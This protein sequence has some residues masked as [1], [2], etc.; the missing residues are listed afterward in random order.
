MTV[1]LLEYSYKVWCLFFWVLCQHFQSSYLGPIIF[2]CE[3]MLCQILKSYI[4]CTSLCISTPRP[5]PLPRQK[6]LVSTLSEKKR[7]LPCYIPTTL[8][9]T[10]Y[11]STILSWSLMKFAWLALST[12]PCPSAAGC[13]CTC[14]QPE[15]VASIQPFTKD[16][17]LYRVYTEKSACYKV[18]PLVM[19]KSW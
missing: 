6:G 17:S 7:S 16:E 2:S 19:D 15:Q 8:M 14:L 1:Q 11:T 9:S 5:C 13:S 18:S 10:K 12:F 3:N 4:T